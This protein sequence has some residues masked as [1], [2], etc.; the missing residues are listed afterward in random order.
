MTA[1]LSWKV[2]KTSLVLTVTDGPKTSHYKLAKSASVKALGETLRAVLA[3]LGSGVPEVPREPAYGAPAAIPGMPPQGL[4]PVDTVGQDALMAKKPIRLMAEPIS[5]EESLMRLKQQ[6]WEWAQK[7]VNFADGVIPDD[8]AARLV[9]TPAHEAFGV[10]PGLPVLDA[11]G[12][13][14]VDGSFISPDAFRPKPKYNLD[15][16]ED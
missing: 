16:H 7:N 14:A 8:T 10:N 9:K 4:G 11:G 12:V 1:K 5:E 3:D 2:E 13:T 6:A 15:N